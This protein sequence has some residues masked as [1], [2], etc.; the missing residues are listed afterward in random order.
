MMT[1]LMID[2]EGGKERLLQELHQRL[3]AIKKANKYK[4]IQ[5][6]Y[7]SR[8][9]THSDLSLLIDAKDPEAIPRFINQVI[10][11]MDGV[12]DIQIIPLL[13]PNFF[14][15]PKG[16]KKKKLKHFTISLDV[17]SSRTEGVFKYL[18][19]IAAE[20]DIPITFLAYTFSSYESD[21]LFTLLAPDMATAGNFVKNKIRKINGV[22]DTILWQIETWK[23]LISDKE[24]R[25]YVNHYLNEY[26]IE[27]DVEQWE[28]DGFI[29]GC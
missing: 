3:K 7:I 12:W 8:C 17:K 23:P 24:W 4:D 1:I 25:V 11:V 28:I 9:F 13:K 29:C 5:V 6:L 22:I 18:R 15:P 16:A 26:K 19:K 27:K 14:E 20:K 10:L 2:V 21:I